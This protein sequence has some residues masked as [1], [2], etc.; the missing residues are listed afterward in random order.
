MILILFSNHFL[1]HD[2][3]FD[4][5]SSFKF[6]SSSAELHKKRLDRFSQN[7][8]ERRHG[9]NC[10]ISVVMRNDVTSRLRSGVVKRHPGTVPTLGV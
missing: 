9:R 10:S 3:D 4:F 2:F 8:V 6:S 7:S 5:K 1:E